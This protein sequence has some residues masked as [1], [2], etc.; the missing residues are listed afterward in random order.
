MSGKFVTVQRWLVSVLI[1]LAAALGMFT[2]GAAPAAAAATLPL[3]GLPRYDHVFVLIEE[4]ESIDKTYGATS[5]ATYLNRTLVPSGVFADHYYGTGHASL[6]NY[7]AMVSGIPDHNALVALDCASLNLYTCSHFQTPFGAGRNLGDQYN[8]KGV[9]WKG[10]MDGTTAAC[11]HADYSPTGAADSWQGNGNTPPPAGKDYADRHNPFLYF[12]DI[13]GDNALCQ[14]HVLPFTQLQVDI[15][16]NAVPQFGF[17]TPDTCHDGHDD[18]CS[19]AAV[20]GLKSADAWLQGNIPN[21]VAYLKS[22]N[23]LLLITTDEG[24]TTDTGGCCTGGLGGVAPGFGGRVGMVAIGPN[25]K[26]GKTVITP[27]DHMSLLRFLED[28]FG[29][30]EHLNNAVGAS[31]LADLFTTSPFGVAPSPAVTPVT[32]GGGRTLPNTMRENAAGAPSAPQR[33]VWGL[34]VVALGLGAGKTLV[35]LRQER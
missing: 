29:I 16:N 28:E 7:I 5:P 19:G 35:K 21:L 11:Q 6:D 30:A 22:H 9:S 34:L 26:T 12:P 27:Y 17:I 1:A 4:N 8:D 33:V 2:A 18:P 14:Q 25:V 15:N 24:Q 31:P 10:Y 13:V 32:A 3:G 23:G 20:G